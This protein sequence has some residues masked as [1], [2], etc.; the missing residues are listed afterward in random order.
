MENVAQLPDTMTRF[1][2]GCTFQLKGDKHKMEF[3]FTPKS[4]PNPFGVIGKV[5]DVNGA[6]HCHVSELWC[7]PER[8]LFHHNILIKP[9]S[10]EVG[11]DDIV[12]L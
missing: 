4:E 5:T 10:V 3:T 8:L 12:I 11:I 2:Q 7:D 6:Y 9:F 1:M